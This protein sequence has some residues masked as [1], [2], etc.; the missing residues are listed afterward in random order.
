[1][2]STVVIVDDHPSFR[3]AAAAVL[4]AAGW[5]VVGEAGDGEEAVREVARTRPEVVLLDVQLPGHDGF[6]VA[7]RLADGAAPPLVVLVS[8]RTAADY[9]D[10]VVRCPAVGFLDK[11]DFTPARLADV[12]AAAG[13]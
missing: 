8:S 4:G 11:A 2:P 3:A 7:R 6:A 5:D 13:G 1:M 9:G 10:A 12:L